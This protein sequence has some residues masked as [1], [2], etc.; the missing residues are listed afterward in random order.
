MGSFLFVATFRREA[1]GS[2]AVAGTDFGPNLGILTFFHLYIWLFIIMAGDKQAFTFSLSSVKW[3]KWKYRIPSS[4]L[5]SMNEILYWSWNKFSAY[6]FSY[7]HEYQF[8]QA[9][10]PTNRNP[11][12]LFDSDQPQISGAFFHDSN[13]S[14]NSGCP[15][16]FESH[17]LNS[18][19]CSHLQRVFVSLFGLVLWKQ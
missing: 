9:I 1:W 18:D 16:Q 13:H 8:F 19:W 15:A 14:D 11:F 12:R 6:L 2:E 4:L 3:N 10:C 5:H 17:R 7:R